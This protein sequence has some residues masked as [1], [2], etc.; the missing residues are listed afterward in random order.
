M[1]PR[2][3]IGAQ[4]LAMVAGL[5][6]KGPLR[7]PC[8]L[9][10]ARRNGQYELIIQLHG[11]EQHVQDIIPINSHFRCVQ[12]AE[13]TLLIDIASNSGCK[14]RVQ[15]DWTRE[16]HFEIPDEERC[17][18]FLSEVLEAQEAQS[19]LL[20]PEQKDSSSW[21]QKLDTMDKPAYSGI[22]KTLSSLAAMKVFE[23]VDR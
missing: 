12:E 20:V 14:I 16:R 7:E 1:E 17:L 10:L 8:V 22:G 5:E 2:L 11:K 4:P 3:P 15:G 6:M 9:T 23:P 19:Q 13:E 18:K 21:Y